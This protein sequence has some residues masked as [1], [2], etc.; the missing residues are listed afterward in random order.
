MKPVFIQ[1]LLLFACVPA[2]AHDPHVP[3]HD[4]AGFVH[5]AEIVVN[6]FDVRHNPAHGGSRR[7]R[8]TTSFEVEA[9]V[10]VRAAVKW[11]VGASERAGVTYDAEI[12]LPPGAAVKDGGAAAVTGV[13]WETPTTWTLTIAGHQRA[14]HDSETWR[15]WLRV[16]VRKRGEDEPVRNV[17]LPV[18]I[19]HKRN[20][21][22]GL[23]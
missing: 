2:A 6:G 10:D 21:P 16:I 23:A 15:A 17:L 13:A 11:S 20:T 3:A 22:F 14:G 19:V 5:S 1:V 18:T 8:E 7:F 12:T 4:P 9:S